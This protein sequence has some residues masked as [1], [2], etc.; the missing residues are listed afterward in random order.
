ISTNSD[1]E[2]EKN[3][4][5]ASPATA[6]AS[7]VL[8]VPGAPT[9]STP[10]GILAPSA[11]YFWGSLRK[12]TTSTSSALASSTPATS[13]KVARSCWLRSWILGRDL[14]ELGGPGPP[15]N[16]R[17]ADAPEQ[18]QKPE[19]REPSQERLLHHGLDSIL[20]EK[21]TLRSSSS[22]TSGASSIP[23][24]RLVTMRCFGCLAAAAPAPALAPSG[25]SSARIS[26]LPSWTRSIRPARR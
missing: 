11:R 21:M 13:S 9:R 15:A 14:P 20:P 5:P 18:P 22:L 2:S 24:R 8:P 6:R 23:G 19:G 25:L 1:P 7:S 10:L 16:P 3:G 12:L 17:H 4:T 26:L